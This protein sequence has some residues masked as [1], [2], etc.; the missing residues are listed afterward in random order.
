M[1]CWG[2]IVSSIM[3]ITGYMLSQVILRL[4]VQK[5]DGIVIL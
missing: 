4:I 1:I 5:V 3:L 2:L